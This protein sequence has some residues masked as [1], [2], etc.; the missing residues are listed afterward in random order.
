V[1]DIL[2]QKIKFSPETRKTYFQDIDIDKNADLFV[3]PDIGIEPPS[4]S[5]YQHIKLEEIDQL[6]PSS[7]RSRVVLVSGIAWDDLLLCRPRREWPQ[8]ERREGICL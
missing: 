2:Q 3:D 7:N 5:D 4:G 8:K 6:L 1:T